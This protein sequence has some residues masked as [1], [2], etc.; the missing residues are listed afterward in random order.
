MLE[1]YVESVVSP[2]NSGNSGNLLPNRQALH[3]VTG[4]NRDRRRA[5]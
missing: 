3:V 1:D 4:H 5:I 2:P